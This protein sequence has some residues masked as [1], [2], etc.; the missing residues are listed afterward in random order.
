MWLLVAALW[1]GCLLGGPPWLGLA[2]PALVIVARRPRRDR[3]RLA[4]A[5]V[6]LV[7][8]GAAVTGGRDLLLDAGP[9]A[10]LARTGGAADLRAVVVAEPRASPAGPWTLVRVERINGRRVRTRAFL[11]LEE[12]EG[13]PALGATVA[14]TAT[15]R[16]LERAGFDAH[17][18]RLHAAVAVDSRSP[19][20]TV[21]GPGALL[22]GTSRVRDRTRAAATRHLD[23]D[24]AALLTGLVAGDTR[25][26]ST[27]RTEQ[28][29]AAGLT[30]LV[31]VSGS[32]VALVVAG[33][34][35]LAAAVG[36]GARARRWLLVAVVLWFVLLVRAEPSVLRAAAMAV[37]VLVAAATGRGTDGRHL[38]GA[39]VLVLL[40]A[41][42]FLAGQLGFALSVGATAGVLLLAPAVAAR[43]PLPRPAAALVGASVGAQ[44]GVAPVLLALPDGVP[45]AA[46]PANLVA[47]PAAAVA[48]AVGAAAAL[49]AQLSVA[50]GGALALL[51]RPALRVVLSAAATFADGPRL[52]AADL[53]SPL[54]ALLAA[55]LLLRR[56]APRTALVAL[57]GVVAAAVVPVV[58]PA[59]PVP[60]PDVPVLTVTAL[61]VG[62]GDAVLVEAPAGGGRP[63][64]RL[65]VDGGPDPAAA[66]AALRARGVRALDA[67]ALS[68][69]HA[70]HS[71]GLPAVLGTM[72]VGVL[73]VG[74]RP[75]PPDAP[76]SVGE[77]LA[78]AA[79]LGVPVQPVADGWRF[80]LG[81]A[82]VEVLG[83]PA[84]GS[85]GDDANEN[86]L[87]LRVEAPGAVA[88]LTGDAEF[89]AQRRLLAVHPG[90]LRADVLKVPHHGGATNADGFLAAVAPATALLSVG[91]DNDYG[92]PA[93]STLTDLAGAEVLR[94]DE[95]G[96]ATATGRRVTGRRAPEGRASTATLSRPSRQEC[97]WPGRCRR[98]SSGSASSSSARAP[99][100]RRS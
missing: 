4:A 47:V 79:R 2:A 78:V 45:L 8:C 89:E 55:A 48:S 37:L 56:R 73:L 76:A 52:V 24:E 70:D 97:R 68:H 29:A 77:T 34:A 3:R 12:L 6:L 13:A 86:S 87:V 26:A 72:P 19:V 11:R 9:L 49:V 15:A 63:A 40:L 46:L 69:P 44:V 74:P 75:P 28:F 31:A 67:V 96:H 59:L 17:L 43:L 7:A 64:G 85:L 42:P 18:R 92:H 100:G 81:A 91:E 20:R 99:R 94:T 82:A 71:D 57:F 51:A 54:A 33:T 98:R 1:A 35:G 39:G 95:D 41:D 27:E 61:D 30:H 83:P 14:F 5:A 22:R 90:R 38:L 53:A 84:D 80:A 65:L 60:V 62:Q 10:R 36:V 88:L 23:R 93:P 66:A 25:G 21:D 32:N 16:P 50:A 58:R